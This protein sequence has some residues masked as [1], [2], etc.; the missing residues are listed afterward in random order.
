M[1]LVR[2][3]SSGHRLG[4]GLRRLR[5]INEHRCSKHLDGSRRHISPLTSENI[6]CIIRETCI[7]SD[8]KGEQEIRA[9]TL[10]LV[11]GCPKRA[12]AAILADAITPYDYPDVSGM[13]R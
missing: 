13:E 6:A 8:E 5:V 7:A 1:L 9:L 2:K 11:H 12:S 3:L 10:R 4:K